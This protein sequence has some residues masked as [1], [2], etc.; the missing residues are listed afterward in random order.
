MIFWAGPRNLFGEE[1]MPQLGIQT[2]LL[3]YAGQRRWTGGA[4][5]LGAASEKK[6]L[7]Q[8]VP[9]LETFCLHRNSKA[10]FRIRDFGRPPAGDDIACSNNI[11]IGRRQYCRPTQDSR[12]LQPRCATWMTPTQ[13]SNDITLP[14]CWKC[15]NI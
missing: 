6:P 9:P 15:A 11:A 8:L 3:Y 7:C 1:I 13:L 12:R 2:L 10:E 14:F 5:I 4:S